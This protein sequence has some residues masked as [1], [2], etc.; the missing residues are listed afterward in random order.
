[1]RKI[2]ALIF[3]AVLT[4]L[5]L[6]GCAKGPDPKSIVI[7]AN[8]GSHLEILQEAAKTLSDKGYKFKIVEFKDELDLNLAVASESID[9]N[10]FQSVSNLNEFNAANGS[11]LIKAADVFVVKD[12]ITGEDVPASEMD[13]LIHVLTVKKGSENLDKIKALVEAIQ[14]DAVREFIK[15][16]YGETLIPKF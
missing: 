10:F 4:V 12:E 16:K 13:A 5:A 6:T 2:I 15:T 7:G 3:A 1:M 14:S 8:A 11:P 9:A